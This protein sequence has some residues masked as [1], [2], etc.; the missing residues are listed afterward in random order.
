MRLSK[1]DSKI[2]HLMLLNRKENYFW[3]EVHR[4]RSGN[5]ASPTQRIAL[6]KVPQFS[7]AWRE[8]VYFLLFFHMV[9][10]RLY[11]PTV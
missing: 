10:Q 7:I 11:S 4:N 8:S 9:N 5:K 1:F 3:H 2:G 6:K